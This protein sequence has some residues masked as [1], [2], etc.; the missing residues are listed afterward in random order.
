MM[1]QQQRKAQAALE[2]VYLVHAPEKVPSVPPIQPQ[3]H[4]NQIRVL[5]N[6]IAK[7]GG[8]GIVS[9]LCLTI[10]ELAVRVSASTATPAETARLKEKKAQYKAVKAQL[11]RTKEHALEDLV[12]ELGF[13]QYQQQLVTSGYEWLEDLCRATVEEMVEDVGMQKPHAE[14]LLAAAR[15]LE[16][17][18]SHPADRLIDDI[19]VLT[20]RV[21]ATLQVDP[22]ADVDALQAALAEKKVQHSHL[23][24]HSLKVDLAA[25]EVAFAVDEAASTCQMVGAADSPAVVAPLRPRFDSQAQVPAQVPDADI[26]VQFSAS[27]VIVRGIV[28]LEGALH[29]DPMGN[30]W[31]LNLFPWGNRVEAAPIKSPAALTPPVSDCVPCDPAEPKKVKA[32]GELT[33]AAVFLEC[34]HIRQSLGIKLDFILKNLVTNKD[35]QLKATEAHRFS[36]SARRACCCHPHIRRSHLTPP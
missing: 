11:Q 1:S 19:A 30:V 7:E 35:V 28:K 31:R 34:V 21:R 6:F 17:D 36:R 24:A 20:L 10:A 15:E 12:S 13:G 5:T 4:A 8:L 2:D 33:H 32:A 23:V 9:K 25:A 3:L 14:L 29:R 27:F 18:A 26:L 16:E 22:S